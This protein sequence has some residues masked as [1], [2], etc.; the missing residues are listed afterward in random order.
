MNLVFATARPRTLPQNENA[1]L[2]SHGC[3]VHVYD[4]DKT[5]QLNLMHTTRSAPSSPLSLSVPGIVTKSRLDG[6]MYGVLPEPNIFPKYNLVER[7]L[8]V[9]P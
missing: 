1:N 7:I 6:S 3:P 5:T 9:F 8:R 2:P 4:V